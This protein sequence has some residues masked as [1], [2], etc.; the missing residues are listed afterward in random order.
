MVD[1][2]LV[3]RDLSFAEMA[4]L[5][6]A[7]ARDLDTEAASID[8]AVRALYASANRQKRNY[9]AHFVILLKAIGDVLKFPEALPRALGLKVEKRLSNDMTLHTELRT[10]LKAANPSMA[11]A[12]LA[13]LKQFAEA[14]GARGRQGCETGCIHRQNHPEICCLRRDSP[15]FRP[16]RQ[17]GAGNGT[18]LFRH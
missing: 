3:R 17:D 11:E 12:E 7:Y 16:Q 9:I 18:R 1:E 15:L 6:L 2:N 5:V 13:V 14:G 10:R 4:Q 8:E